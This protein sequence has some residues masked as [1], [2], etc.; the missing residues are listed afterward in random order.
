MQKEI[1]FRTIQKK[2]KLMR[3][4][5]THLDNICSI[6][7]HQNRA[8]PLYSLAYPIPAICARL[9]PKLP[10][11]KHVWGSYTPFNFFHHVSLG[12][13]FAKNMKKRMDK[14]YP[15][16]FRCV[17]MGKYWQNTFEHMIV[18]SPIF[19]SFQN[20]QI[21]KNS[22]MKCKILWNVKIV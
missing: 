5:I 15:Q 17:T 22:F 9:S 10:P 14:I 19:L 18:F 1:W 4:N 2:K 13:Q 11:C 12:L 3:L 16:V 20:W 8:G 6:I 21:L 7:C